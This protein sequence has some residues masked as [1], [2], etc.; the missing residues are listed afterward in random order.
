MLRK[1]VGRSW[2]VAAA[3]VAATAFM[4]PLGHAVAQAGDASNIQQNGLESIRVRN[5]RSGLMAWM[6]DPAHNPEPIEVH[7]V[8]Q[9]GGETPRPADI[10]DLPADF[11]LPAGIVS[12]TSIDAQNTLAVAGTPQGVKQLRAIV[13]E[14]D[15]RIPQVEVEAKFVSLAPAEFEQL[16]IADFM[17]AQAPEVGELKTGALPPDFHQ[18]LDSL[19]AQGKA[20]IMNSPRVT[21]MYRVAS[22]LGSRITVP[23]QLTVDKSNS[24]LAD[25][26]KQLDALPRESQAQ[27]G[28][29][30]FLRA[31]PTAINGDR[32]TLE[33]A[34]VQNLQV[35]ESWKPR[36]PQARARLESQPTVTLKSTEQ[37]TVLTVKDG[38]SMLIRGVYPLWVTESLPGAGNFAVVTVKTIRRSE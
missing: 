33:L 36:A 34:T 30:A 38:E 11:K 7:H 8:R 15:R 5:M 9:A 13:E 26:Q 21:T 25:L 32:V 24:A 4:A 14:R 6:L 17:N 16:G 27:V 35:T 29:Y 37:S 22:Q 2:K 31:K 18:R 12:I 19:V 10:F 28:V 20:R 1:S 23:A 3:F